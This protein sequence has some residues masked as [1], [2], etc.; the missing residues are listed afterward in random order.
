MVQGGVLGNLAYRE[1]EHGWALELGQQSARYEC[2]SGPLTSDDVPGY[3]DART[4]TVQYMNELLT[5]NRIRYT[6][7]ELL[8]GVAADHHKTCGDLLDAMKKDATPSQ[9]AFYLLGTAVYYLSLQDT[10]Y[11]ATMVGLALNRLKN[12]PIRCPG[13]R[14][15]PNGLLE[16]FLSANDISGIGIR[17]VLADLMNPMTILVVTADPVDQ[18]PLRLLQESRQ[19]IQALKSANLQNAFKVEQLPSCQI[20][21]LA[22]GIRQHKPAI[23]HFSG[24]GSEQGLCFEGPNG[25]AVILDPD[26]FAA[27]L[28]LA[29]KE[30]LKGVVMNACNSQVHAHCAAEAVGQVIAMEGPLSDEAAIDFAREFYGCMGDGYTFER[31]FEWAL[32]ASGLVTATGDLKPCLIQADRV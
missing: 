26:K 28:V 30:G 25:D 27:L 9:L 11:Q 29:V 32:T 19:L 21:D 5:S 8:P 14:I 22:T 23:L 24:H 4:S 7:P 10:G 20:R 1:D 2:I 13:I 17:S 16:C 18:A 6:V 3:D 12:I 15:E 31:A